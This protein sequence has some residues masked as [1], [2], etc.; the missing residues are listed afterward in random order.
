LRRPAEDGPAL[1]PL[2]G[3]VGDRE[4][5]PGRAELAAV[6]GSPSVVV[7][8]VLGEDQPQVSFAEDQ[9][10]VGDGLPSGPGPELTFV[11]VG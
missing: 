3:E 10:P 5:W 4:V 9:H 8:L 1:D 7:R 11:T 6:M 2:L